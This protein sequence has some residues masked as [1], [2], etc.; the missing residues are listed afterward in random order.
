MLSVASVS[1]SFVAVSVFEL[2]TESKFKA[3]Q[4]QNSTQY[5][6]Q[7]LKQQQMKLQLTQQKASVNDTK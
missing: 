7:K 2:N 6:A 1:V 4:L 3:E 5:S